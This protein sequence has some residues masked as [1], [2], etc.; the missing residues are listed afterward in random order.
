VERRKARVLEKISESHGIPK[1]SPKSV[2]RLADKVTSSRL[3]LPPTRTDAILSMTYLRRK[4]L[5]CDRSSETYL[6][7]T[8]PRKFLASTR[9]GMLPPFTQVDQV[10]MVRQV[11]RVER[12]GTQTA[13]TG[14][15]IFRLWP[16]IGVVEDQDQE[17][18]PRGIAACRARPSSS[19]RADGE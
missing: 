6:G 15:V 5:R 3:C 14:P 12:T 7:A 17:L 19:L 4:S 13:G 18:R 1:P 10:L 11:P 9:P 2:Y 16:Y 8:S